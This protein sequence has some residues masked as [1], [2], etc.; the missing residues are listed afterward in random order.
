MGFTPGVHLKLYSTTDR[1]RYFLPEKQYELNH[2]VNRT[3][4]KQGPYC[5]TRNQKLQ[6]LPN[7]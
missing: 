6:V 3:A 2:K 7:L 4:C 1:Y 5:T